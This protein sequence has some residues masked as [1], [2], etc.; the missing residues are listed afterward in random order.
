MTE[1]EIRTLLKMGNET[2]TFDDE[3]RE[4]IDSVFA[5]DDRTAREIMVPRREVYTLNIEE[6]LEY[7]LDENFGDEAYKNSCV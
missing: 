6:P 7:I 5:F 3:E 1:E 4:M 2:G